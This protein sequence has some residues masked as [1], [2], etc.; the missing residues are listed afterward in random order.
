MSKRI[1]RSALVNH[2]AEQMFDLVHDFESYPQYM[3]GCVGTELLDRGE[4]WLEARLD[5]SKAGLR[6]SFVTH[7]TMRRPESMHIEL[8]DGPFKFFRGEWTFT[9]L[10]EAACRVDFWLEFEFSNRLVGFATGKLIEQVAS[11]QV[12]A[13]CKRADAVY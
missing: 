5:L 2:T 12:S 1:E 13:L 6:Q 10:S 11:E 9:T 7:N 8:V 3:S 4:D